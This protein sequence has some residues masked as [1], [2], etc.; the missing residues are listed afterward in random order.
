MLSLTLYYVVQ[1]LILF[2]LHPFSSLP[3]LFL[4]RKKKLKK[5]TYSLKTQSVAPVGYV[6]STMEL[7]SAD[8]LL[9]LA[10]MLCPLKHIYILVV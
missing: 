5:T 3:I 10:V 8:K 6:N 7:F 9:H 2:I 1:K 4:F